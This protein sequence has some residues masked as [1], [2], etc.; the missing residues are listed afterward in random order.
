MKEADGTNLD[1]LHAAIGIQRWRCV[2]RVRPRAWELEVPFR[3]IP[4]DGSLPTGEA[5][6][7]RHEEDQSHNLAE[8]RIWAKEEMP[9]GREFLHYVALHASA[10]GVINRRKFKY[11]VPITLQ[12]KGFERTDVDKAFN[13]K[14]DL[15]ELDR[16]KYPGEWILR[17]RETEQRVLFKIPAG[18]N[19]PR[20]RKLIDRAFRRMLE[21][22]AHVIKA[23]QGK[24]GLS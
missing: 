3:L 4:A 11:L 7:V 16:E 15:L 22:N 18:T 10:Y 6:I 19:R 1:W 21:L 17:D 8:Q 20:Q 9:K 12:L 14:Y 5:I 13:E 23:P 2:D 24:H